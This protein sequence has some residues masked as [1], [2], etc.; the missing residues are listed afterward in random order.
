MLPIIKYVFNAMK[1]TDCHHLKLAL[2]KDIVMVV[3]ML[4]VSNVTMITRNAH[5]ATHI[6]EL[7][8][9]TLIVNCV[10]IHIA[11]TAVSTIKY[12]SN[13]KTQ[14]IVDCSISLVNYV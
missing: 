7:I 14:V 9:M 1:S 12:V 5:S 10:R 6:M 4:S 11:E 3:R 13:A 2:K 8:W